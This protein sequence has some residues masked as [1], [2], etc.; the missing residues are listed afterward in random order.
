[1]Q[2][3]LIPQI[4]AKLERTKLIVLKLLPLW[5]TFESCHRN[6][7]LGLFD[8]VI[9]ECV[10]K[11]DIGIVKPVLSGHSKRALNWFSIPIIA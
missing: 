6:F 11:I 4:N 2:Y 7:E 3:I 8:M 1:M 9:I 5:C 10:H